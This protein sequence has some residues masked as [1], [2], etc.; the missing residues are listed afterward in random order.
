MGEAAQGD[1][2]AKNDALTGRCNWDDDESMSVHGD[3][4]NTEGAAR[5]GIR[6]DAWRKTPAGLL[7]LAVSLALGLTLA[8]PGAAQA[9]RT[10]S[11]VV[12]GNT[13]KILHADRPD[14]LRY[15]ASMTK[16]MTLF[17]VFDELERGRLKFTSRIPISARAARATPSK[18][19]LKAGSSISV[20]DAIKALITKS[21]NDIAIAVAERLAGSERA[22]ARRMT[23]RAHQLGMSKT[24]FTNASGLPDTDQVSTARDMLKMATALM[25]IHGRH[26]HLFSMR[27]FTYKGRRYRNHNALLRNFP[28]TDGLKTGY[29]RAS[30]F[31]LVASA[32]RKGKHVIGVVFGGKTSSER[33][34]KMR[35][36]L[37]QAFKRASTR[38]T[39]K[40]IGKPAPL[41]VSRAKRIRRPADKRGARVASKTARASA[42]TA[43]MRRA[44]P[45]KMRVVPIAPAKRQLPPAAR[46]AAPAF[47]VS[48]V[49][50]VRF[51]N[52]P[53]ARNDV[54]ARASVYGANAAMPSR[55]PRGTYEAP[56]TR[57]AGP[58]AQRTQRRL[59]P[60]RRQRPQRQQRLTGRAP[61]TFAAQAAALERD[62][63]QAYR[64]EVRPYRAP[65]QRRPA[66]ADDRTRKYL[67]GPTPDKQAV[68]RFGAPREMR[69]AV[70]A[71][72]ATTANPAPPPLARPQ[73]AQPDYARPVPSQAA[74]YRPQ[75]PPQAAPGATPRAAPTLARGPYHVQIGAYVTVGEAQQRL[76]EVEA[77]AGNLLDGYSSVTMPFDKANKR[78]YRAR[79]AGFDR[80]AA[81]STCRQ[82]KR[83]NIDCYVTR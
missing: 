17:L 45:R 50:P 40:P 41:L 68:G 46:A 4:Y 25:D 10:S 79:F 74:A 19:G 81:S 6:F 32:R 23:K 38:K 60:Q 67:G 13:G 49:R 66:I 73:F 75:R 61:S 42:S 52:A 77:R 36:L 5:R 33:N 9:A 78:Y 35:Y 80:S 51:R 31:N 83:Q 59:R 72:P 37:T 7:L 8:A 48:R 82:L 15:P 54:P 29:T 58:A 11:M 44:A 12:D 64:P 20:R 56:S 39:R 34:R 69:Q 70:F 47:S 14:A 30:G 21:A 2:P 26:Y 57:S 55:L 62:N 71:P 24:R 22:F 18:L 76:S 16:V 27:A 28:G 43:R 65:A 3:E 53:P 63:Q 1:E